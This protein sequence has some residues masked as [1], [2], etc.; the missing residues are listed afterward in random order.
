MLKYTAPLRDIRFSLDLVGSDDLV[1]LPGFEH[2]DTDTL[3]G[4]LD[5][6][7]RLVSDTWGETNEPGDR[8]G[9]N[10]NVADG[11]IEAPPGF[12]EAYRA[13]VDGGWAS[14]A[15]DA[16]YGGGNFPH[17][18]GIAMSEL[19]QSAN[20]ALALLP[21]LT[22][23]AIDA[24]GHYGSEEQKEKYLRKLVSGEWTGTM[25]LTEPDAGSDVGALRAKAVLAADG[26]WRITGQKIYITWG[27][28]SLTDNIVHLVLARVDGSPTG[29]KGISC[30]IVPKFLVN[31]DGS[32]G[33]RNDV[34][35]VST[36]HKMGIH[37]SPTCVLAFG[38]N[39]DGAVGE[40]IG[41]PN[42][43]MRTMFVMMNN[44]RLAVGQQGL[45]VAERA[46]Q[47]AVAHALS[48]IQGRPL[49]GSANDPIVGHPDV[50]RML[51]TMR[52]HIEAMRHLVFLN[53]KAIDEG[54]H[55][56]SPEARAAAVELAD[57][58]TPL[59]KA[60]CTD[61]GNELCSL[62][63]QV[64]GGMGFVEDTGVAQLYRDVRIAAIYE[65]TN[66]IQA[67][68]LYGRKLGLRSGEGVADLINRM[69]A[70]VQVV[71]Q[72]HE[73]E[74]LAAQI[75]MAISTMEHLTKWMLNEGRL[76]PADGMSGA[77]PYL[78]VVATVVG[79]WLMGK[80]AV[81]AL[82]APTRDAFTEAKVATALF[83][84]EQILSTIDGLVRQV[85]S[86]SAALFA[87]PTD[88]LASR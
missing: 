47:H 40:L 77:T 58:L 33:E 19:I 21:M 35:L 36:E 11:T 71:G 39:G 72:H 50:R 38:D 6:F 20:M 60:W 8:H 83:Y 29:T 76:N 42:A 87:V 25:N 7:G 65:G 22:Q 45:A 43:G 28:H 82:T 30:F 5:E 79:G 23:G 88:S 2:A 64:H 80:Q 1:A 51:M 48:R 9:L 10:V 54:R 15:A 56:A 62:A 78:R 61:L 81:Q 70:D 63:V 3:M 57:I 44:A 41:E 34:K 4:L 53:A 18:S 31:D 74:T 17:L 49:G 13:Y 73:L 32:I 27:E 16:A 86:G 69:L 67:L 52:S 84:G 37:A 26:T 59:S 24:L 14:V 75:T 46:Y 66:G 85:T 12:A 55:G 68:D